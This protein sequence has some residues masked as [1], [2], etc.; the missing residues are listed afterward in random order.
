M[1]PGTAVAGTLAGIAMK[2]TGECIQDQLSLFIIE[3]DE[4][5]I[6]CPSSDFGIGGAR[7]GRSG[8]HLR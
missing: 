1:V 4:V 2:Q 5:W 6:I 3:V 7:G 8:R